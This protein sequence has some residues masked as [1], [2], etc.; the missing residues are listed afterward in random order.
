MSFSFDNLKPKVIDYNERTETE[1]LKSVAHMFADAMVSL[2]PVPLEVVARAVG[3]ANGHTCKPTPQCG[4]V[5][6]ETRILPDRPGLRATQCDP[7][8]WEG[9]HYALDSG[10]DCGRFHDG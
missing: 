10:G 1:P 7:L 5:G 2:R 9:A 3:L 6:V 8:T 4:P